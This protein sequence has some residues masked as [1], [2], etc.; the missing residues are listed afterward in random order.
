MN[1]EY[2]EGAYYYEHLY[3]AWGTEAIFT[4]PFIYAIKEVDHI[5]LCYLND[6]M[7]TERK[8][9]I[10]LPFEFEGLPIRLDA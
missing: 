8:G 4:D 6:F 5:W 9:V 1:C 10:Y 2:D 3:L 7:Q